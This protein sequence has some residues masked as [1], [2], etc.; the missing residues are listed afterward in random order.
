[1][2]ISKYSMFVLL[3]VLFAALLL[4]FGRNIFREVSRWLLWVVSAISVCVG[5]AVFLAAEGKPLAI[6]GGVILWTFAAYAITVA[7][8]QRVRR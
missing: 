7:K 5:A 3:A 2:G 8:S 1:M 6:L 4:L